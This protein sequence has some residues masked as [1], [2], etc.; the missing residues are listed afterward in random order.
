MAAAKTY[1]ARDR[2]EEAG[3]AQGE[4]V[5]L[6]SSPGGARCGDWRTAS[7]VRAAVAGVY[8][9]SGLRA[10]QKVQLAHRIHVFSTLTGT[11][12]VLLREDTAQVPRP[13]ATAFHSAIKVHRSWLALALGQAPVLR[14]NHRIGN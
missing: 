8:E 10:P 6:T 4:K 3:K 11:E 2:G 12:P 1:A 5:H 7:E 13:G 14:S 9:S